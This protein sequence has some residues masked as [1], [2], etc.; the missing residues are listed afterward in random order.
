MQSNGQDSTGLCTHRPSFPPSPHILGCTSFI[1]GMQPIP[2]SSHSPSL[3]SLGSYC[4]SPCILCI[5]T[6]ARSDPRNAEGSSLRPITA[7]APSHKPTVAMTLDSR[8]IGVRTT[9]VDRHA[10]THRRR[11]LV[12]GLCTCVQCRCTYVLLSYIPGCA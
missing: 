2:V 6:S 7:L 11:G 12:S 1:H 3:L 5:C 8:C 9:S 4:S 10:Q